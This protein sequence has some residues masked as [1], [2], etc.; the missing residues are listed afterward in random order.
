MISKAI[1]EHIL[2]SFEDITPF[3]KMV[4]DSV[5]SGKSELEL[6]NNLLSYCQIY[7]TSGLLEIVEESPLKVKLR[8]GDRW[9][10]E[11]PPISKR[12]KKA[13]KEYVPKRLLDLAKSLGY[14]IDWE[15][16]KGKYVKNFNRI[17]KKFEVKELD[18]VAQFVEENNPEIDLNLFLTESSFRTL[19]T[20]SKYKP[21]ID[22]KYQDR[23][24]ICDYNEDQIY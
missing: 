14:P 3:L 2:N 17:V 22:D 20:K 12:E 21:V 18:R 11:L 15:V 7:Q 23:V 5:V 1:A 9:Y 10:A 19:Q 13:K 16:N 24:D 8:E 6:P 4:S